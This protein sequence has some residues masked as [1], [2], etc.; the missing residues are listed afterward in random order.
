[1]VIIVNKMKKYLFLLI[2]MMLVVGAMVSC[3]VIS[4]EQSTEESE[5]EQTV[6]VMGSWRL[7]SIYGAPAE[8]DIY[9]DFGKNG[10]FTICQRT[11]ELTYSVFDGHYTVNEE[12]SIVSGVYS[13]G[14]AW[15]SDYKYSLDEQALSLVL[16]SVNNPAEIAVYQSADMPDV[17]LRKA[18]R[19]VVSDVKPL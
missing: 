2:C 11:E 7:T 15:N 17:S 3:Q 12:E 6:A 13:D 10:V 9:I 8:V 4:P 18:S 5:P 19:A 14:T 1:M 16:E